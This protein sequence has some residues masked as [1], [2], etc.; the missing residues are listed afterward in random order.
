MDL[1]KYAALFLAESREHLTAC[2]GSLLEWER[3]P[4]AG[5]PV[6]RLFRAIHTIKGM[7]A[8]MGYA[9]VAQLAHAAE[10]LLDALR[11]GR[12]TATPSVFQLLFRS[13]DTLGRA[14]ERAAEGSDDPPDSGLIGELD[15]VAAG[16]PAPSIS[17]AP[18][19]IG[20]DP[21]ARRASDAPRSRP[22]QVTIRPSAAMRG[23]RAALV[24]RRAETMGTVSGL[25]PPTAQL[26]LD[27]F[28]G[29]FSFRLQTKVS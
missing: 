9:P 17:P 10:N 15:A 13:V 11:Q 26:E 24:L 6:D 27:E 7:A 28:D 5:E 19:P 21:R 14:V 23:A 20:V 25:R 8:T 1:S 22:V 29:R 2:N 3:D 18:E 12:L 4:S 16:S